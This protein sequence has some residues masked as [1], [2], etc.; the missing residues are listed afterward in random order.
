M[1]V[2]TYAYT[3][4]CVYVYMYVCIYIYMYT[5]NYGNGTNNRWFPHNKWFVLMYAAS[6]EPSDCH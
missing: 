3:Y 1:Y 2:H 4:V 6:A 5:C